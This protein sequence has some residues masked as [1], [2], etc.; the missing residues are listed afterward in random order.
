M[1]YKDESIGTEWESNSVFSRNWCNGKSLL[2]YIE[3]NMIAAWSEC[4]YIHKLFL[5]YAA[6]GC[7]VLSFPIHRTY[8]I[9]PNKDANKTNYFVSCSYF[10]TEIKFKFLI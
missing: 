6:Q 5:N 7:S 3:S 1:W 8:V 10:Y 9:F 4:I 2:S